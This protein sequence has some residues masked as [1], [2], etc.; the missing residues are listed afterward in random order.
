MMPALLDLLLAVVDDYTLQ[1]C[2][3]M[4]MTAEGMVDCLSNNSNNFE[5]D[6]CSR[7]GL[8]GIIRIPQS[9]SISNYNKYMGGVDLADTYEVSAL[10]FN[11]NGSES[12]VLVEFFSI[13]SMLELQMHWF[14]TTKQ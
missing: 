1:L 3:N 13:C 12:V 9:V 2:N 14:C 11:N 8:G 10:Q 4:P 6:E 7:R 5:F